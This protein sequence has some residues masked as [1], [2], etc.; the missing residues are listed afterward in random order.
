MKKRVMVICMFDSIHSA[1]WLGQFQDQEIEF[2]LFPSSPHRR[3]H[4]QLLALLA[5]DSIASYKLFPGSKLFGLPLWLADKFLNN[6][7]RGNLVRAA[8]RK[9]KPEIVHSLELQ[10]A[11]YIAARAFRSGKPEGVRFIAT[12]WGSDIFW[13]QNFPRHHAKLEALL[14]MADAYSCE[15]ERDVELAK[16]LGFKGQVMP[17]IPNAGGFSQATLNAVVPQLNER[18][19][20]AVK[21]YHGWVGRAK[22]ALEAIESIQDQCKDLKIVVYS[23]NGTTKKFV[24]QLTKRSNLEIE[25]HGKGQLSHSQV[26]ELFSKAKIYVGL[27]LSDGISTSLL[28]SMAMGAI[29][30]QTSTACCDEWFTD[31]GVAV[32]E[33]TAD[34]VAR[35]ILQGLDLA[36]NQELSDKNRSI[37]KQRA[38]A[39]EVA[40]IAKGFYSS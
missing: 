7:I 10:N 22:V 20:I 33:I 26:L 38:D 9:F 35:A 37:I 5:A 29:P 40:L 8:I 32:N 23:A 21:G 36:K 25:V 39:N 28:E 6:A 16:R 34:S 17:V 13:F 2:L 1:R 18:S 30:V 3:V 31:S 14:S 27:S 19:L 15:C 4:K 24:R 12:N 11:G